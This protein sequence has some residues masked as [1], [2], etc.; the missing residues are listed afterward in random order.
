MP[1]LSGPCPS[2]AVIHPYV[3][4]LGVLLTLTTLS[5]A[6]LA[7]PRP[8]AHA[9]TSCLLLLQELK[10]GA[11][12]TML[13]SAH[14]SSPSIS[15]TPTTDNNNARTPAATPPLSLSLTVADAYKNTKHTYS[16]TRDYRRHGVRQHG[17]P[18]RRYARAR[19][20]T[21]L[22]PVGAIASTWP[23]LADMDLL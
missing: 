6:R 7:P 1:E 11:P 16:T 10:A 8:P 2:Q 15:Y 14:C 12:T 22:P 9:C 17:Q 4:C 21:K 19:H 20:P 23:S 13:H 18:Q 5:Q 3:Q